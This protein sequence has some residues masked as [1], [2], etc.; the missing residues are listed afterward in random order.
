MALTFNYEAQLRGPYESAQGFL[1]A[2]FQEWQAGFQPLN[3]LLGLA[4]IPNATLTTDSAGNPQ[5]TVPPPTPG[6]GT[7]T[8]IGVSVPAASILSVTN[9][10]ITTSGIIA[11]ATSGTSGGVPYFSDSATLSTSSAL[12]ANA[13]VLGGGAGGAPTTAAWS[14]FTPV[15]TFGGATTGITYTTQ[16]GRYLKLGTWVHLQ[17]AIVLSS[18]GSATGSAT[19]TGL[20]ATSKNSTSYRAVLATT[21]DTFGASTF[22]PTTYIAPNGTT[23]TLTKGIV[24]GTLTALADTDCTNTTSLWITGAYETS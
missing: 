3:P 17:I 12:T 1:I 4:Y 20:P 7:V 6:T 9:S 19:L 11:M 21:G 5:F 22:T 23:A 18:K 15:L 13:P 14:T 2:Q 10:P 24:A 8:S 16:T